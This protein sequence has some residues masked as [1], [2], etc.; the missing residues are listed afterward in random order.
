MKFILFGAGTMGLSA[1]AHLGEDCVECFADNKKHGTTFCGKRVISFD[2][3]VKM[4]EDF[5]IVIATNDYAELFE[6][7]LKAAGVEQ[8]ILWT[9]RFNVDRLRKVLPTYNG[10]FCDQYMSYRDALSYHGIGRYK[11]IVIYGSNEYIDY[12]LLEIAMLNRL[13]HVIGIVDENSRQQDYLGIPIRPLEEMGEFDCLLVNKRRAD[14]NIRD[15][16]FVQDNNFDILDIYDSEKFISYF[17][18]PELVKFKDIHKGRRAFIIGNGPSLTI[19]DLDMLHQHHEIC[20]AANH[21]YKIYAQTAWRPDYLCMTDDICIFECRDKFDWLVKESDVFVA[22][23]VIRK[24]SDNP[25]LN[26]VHLLVS[27]KF[28]P[29][30]PS[31]SSDI[32][33]GTYTGGN[34]IYGL[35]LQI[36]AYMGFDELYLLGVDNSFSGIESKDHFIKDYYSPTELEKLNVKAAGLDKMNFTIEKITYE[37]AC[38]YQK[39][40]LYSRKH[41]FR[42]YNATRGGKLEV[43]ERVD[44]DTLF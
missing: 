25:E 31:F 22:D 26:L 8:Y 39:A 44:F 20:F 13:A 7:Q 35:A 11:K 15:V 32:T 42:I 6:E 5:R 17:H 18:H 37:M 4:A 16:L 19:E 21:I 24:C 1:L 12:L 43:F 28:A 29:N 34:V 27:G 41:G 2:E 3:M 10:T 38:G 36:A 23:Q 9:Q 30:M 14:T 33:T 40:E